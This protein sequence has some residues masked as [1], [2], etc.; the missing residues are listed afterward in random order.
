MLL[1][2][3]PEPGFTPAGVFIVAKPF[4]FKLDYKID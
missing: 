4:K 1:D 3:F 2:L